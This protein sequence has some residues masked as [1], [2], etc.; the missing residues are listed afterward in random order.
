[1]DNTL[2]KIDELD[3]QI[4]RAERLENELRISASVS[5]G[6]VNDNTPKEMRNYSFQDAM[7]AAVSGKME[8]LVKE[9]DTKRLE[10]KTQAKSIK[11]LE[12]LILS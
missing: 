7:K 6:K 12:Y 5:G 1:M 11:A 4:K 2:D 10:E 8:G 3:A 9:M